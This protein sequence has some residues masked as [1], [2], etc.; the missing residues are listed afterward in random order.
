VW[1]HHNEQHF[2]SGCNTFPIDPHPACGHLLPLQAA[3]EGIRGEHFLFFGVQL[4]PR[5]QAHAKGKFHQPGEG[6][7]FSRSGEFTHAT[8]EY[9]RVRHGAHAG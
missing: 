6:L 4:N 7:E 8:T 5:E 1:L 9:L 3:G 2:N